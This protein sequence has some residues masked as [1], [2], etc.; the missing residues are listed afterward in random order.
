M[1]PWIRHRVALDAELLLE[2]LS[3]RD[4]F[5]LGSV[6]VVRI[7]V[8]SIRVAHH[9]ARAVPAH[10]ALTITISATLDG[11]FWLIGSGDRTDPCYNSSEDKSS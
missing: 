3:M 6:L 9:H 7:A 2:S 4:T 11:G 1:L 10:H 8:S 5:V